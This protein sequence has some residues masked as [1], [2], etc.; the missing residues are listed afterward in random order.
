MR[1]DEFL[2]VPDV[3]GEG[4]VDESLHALRMRLLEAAGQSAH[5]GAHLRA[6]Q[7]RGLLEE[8]MRRTFG[9]PELFL[10]LLGGLASSG[11]PE[12]LRETY[13]DPAYILLPG[14][15]ATAA[16]TTR[17]A[18]VIQPEL[19]VMTFV[20]AMDELERFNALEEAQA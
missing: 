17:D 7:E 13:P 1:R 2:A 18:I 16:A 8:A 4:G 12:R 11:L 19:D 15:D 3:A 10:L 5:M 6:M 14:L 9:D 20:E